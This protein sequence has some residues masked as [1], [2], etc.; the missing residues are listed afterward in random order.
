MKTTE[1]TEDLGAVDM[2]RKGFFWEGSFPSVS[3]KMGTAELRFG[4]YPPSPCI[5]LIASVYAGCSDCECAWGVLIL[6][7][8]ELAGK[9][10][11]IQ[12]LARR[13][14]LTPLFPPSTSSAHLDF[15]ARLDVTAGAVDILGP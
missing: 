2:L 14:R 3:S 7:F 15:E 6:C 5:L 11:T 10:L 4:G 9:I 1:D 13:S 12:E 8:L